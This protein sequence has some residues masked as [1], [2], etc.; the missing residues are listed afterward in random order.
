M[1][2]TRTSPTGSAAVAVGGP[3]L[4]IEPLQREVEARGIAL[5]RGGDGERLRKAY[6]RAVRRGGVSVLHA[7]E[8]SVELLGVHPYEIWG[9]E[10][11]EV[12][13]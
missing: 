8:L 1:D 9:A 7:D 6:H 2:T 10:W 4:S 13:G 11:F 3:W 12:A 5:P